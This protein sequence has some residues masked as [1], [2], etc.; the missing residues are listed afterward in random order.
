M[1]KILLINGSHPMGR[2]KGELNNTLTQTADQTLRNMGRQ[3]QTT[4]ATAGYTV[5]EEINKFLWADAV[6]YNFPVYWMG[7]PGQFKK[8]ID[9][10]FIQSHGKLYA[11]DGRD[12]GKSYGQGGLMQ[13]RK[14]MF[15]ATWNAPADAFNTPGQF[16]EDRDA[17][18][19]LYPLHKAQRFLGMAPL[20]SFHL[21]DVMRKPRVEEYLSEYRAHLEKT[22]S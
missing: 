15:V 8:Y 21:F 19:L 4:I 7:I 10:V 1:E 11:G 14:Y 3:T 17:D 22:F 9:E 2:A 5:E 6:I 13:D 16:F 20:P 18:G 12:L